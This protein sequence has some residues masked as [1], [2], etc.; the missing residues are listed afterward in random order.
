MH[1]GW[2]G[3]W[4]LNLFTGMRPQACFRMTW[5]PTSASVAMGTTRAI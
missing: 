1:W 2:H 4:Q 5:G 3:S